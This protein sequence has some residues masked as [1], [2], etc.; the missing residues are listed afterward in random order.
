MTLEL[1]K[2]IL[3]CGIFSQCHLVVKSQFE[4]KFGKSEV[5]RLFFVQ[6][7]SNAYILCVCFILQTNFRDRQLLNG[8]FAQKC[9]AKMDATFLTT[10]Y[11]A[12]SPK[13]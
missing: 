5:L 2:L 3:F 7:L 12:S 4:I 9:V 1:W 13:K 11:G 6:F 10:P 8:N